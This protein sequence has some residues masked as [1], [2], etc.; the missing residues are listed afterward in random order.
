MLATIPDVPEAFTSGADE[1]AR[2]VR[3][4]LDQ[5]EV[6]AR[7]LFRTLEVRVA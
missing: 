3:S 6:A 7:V 2:S 4:A 1:E 5:I